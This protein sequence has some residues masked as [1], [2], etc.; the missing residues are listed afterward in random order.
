MSISKE[1]AEI[2]RDWK[3][4]TIGTIGSHTGKQIPSSAKRWGFKTLVVVEK[5]REELYTKFNPWLYD[6]VIPVGHFRDMLNEEVQ[7]ALLERKVIWIPNRSFAVYVGSEEIRDKFRV[8][9]FGSRGLLPTEDRDNKRGQYYLLEKAGIPIPMT[10]SSPEEIDR[11]AIV[12]L[13]QAK[14][15][16]ERADFYAVSSEDFL[17]EAEER[18]KSG[19]INEEGIKKARI[20]EYILG[21]K[22]NAD[23]HSH[24]LKDIFGDFAFVGFG[25]RIQVPL[26]GFLDLPAEVQLKLKK[27]KIKIHVRNVEVGHRAAISMRESIQPII[28]ESGERFIRTCEAEYPPGII[29]SFSLQGAVRES[30]ESGKKFEFV[31]FDVSPRVPGDLGIG[32]TSPEMPILSLKYGL[33]IIDPLDLTMMEI[34]KA[35]ETN[36]LSE[37]VT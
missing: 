6:S 14:N 11:L 25:D 27:L 20:E 24:A 19:L 36:R 7:R 16:L 8:P 3:N 33:G 12:K 32:P 9:M 31:V 21:A 2:V 13:P 35:L 37:I 30:V 4:V 28:Y 1:L 10:F 23:F 5:G 15:P 22:F 29:G 18:L 17:D 26:Q 34:K